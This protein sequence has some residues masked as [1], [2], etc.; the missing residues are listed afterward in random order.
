MLFSFNVNQHKQYTINYTNY[1]KYLQVI[2]RNFKAM[3][4]INS[5]KPIEIKKKK[6]SKTTFERFP[7]NISTI[8]LNYL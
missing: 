2:V 1:I 7:K 6:N 8:N 4:R 3:I 5:Q